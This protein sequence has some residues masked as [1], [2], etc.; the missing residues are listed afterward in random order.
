MYRCIENAAKD[1]LRRSDRQVRQRQIE[2]RDT[3]PLNH[4]WAA[5]DC[6]RHGAGWVAC[7]RR[8]ET[9]TWRSAV[10]LPV[11]ATN[12]ASV[13]QHVE[14]LLQSCATLMRLQIGR[15]VAC[16]H[17]VRSAGYS[18][19][20]HRPWFNLRSH[21]MFATAG[22]LAGSAVVRRSPQ[23][24]ADRLRCAACQ[25]AACCRLCQRSLH[26]APL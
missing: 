8:N 9:D 25:V 22:S 24:N 5:H 23:R 17:A 26:A 2:A 11:P 13:A 16:I 1:Q 14:R 21:A 15:D 7:S 18:M 6:G 4:H 19:H 3:M 20:G 12:A 10:S